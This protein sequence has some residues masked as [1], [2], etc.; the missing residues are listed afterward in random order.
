MAM[1]NPTVALRLDAQT[2]E[3]LKHLGQYKDRSPHY[4]MK[5]AVEKYL[6]EEE[7]L[8]AELQLTHARWEKFA[9]TGEAIANEDI[10]SWAEGLSASPEHSQS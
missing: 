8:Q 9:L 7:A 5:E 4:L 2:Q 10:T 6:S 3:R 1:A